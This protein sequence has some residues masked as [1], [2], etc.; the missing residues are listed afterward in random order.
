MPKV[1]EIKFLKC[2]IKNLIILHNLECEIYKDL[3]SESISH[4]FGH[5]W[6]YADKRYYRTTK[7]HKCNSFT[8]LIVGGV[9]A[10]LGEFPHMAA[11]GWKNSDG[12]VS[13]KCGG[14]L[15]SS[16]FVLTVAHCGSDKLVT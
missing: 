10:K 13:F 8:G 12:S 14:S 16:N 7:V 2:C 5:V 9:P 15:V 6:Q 11:I 4:F 1:F 3:V